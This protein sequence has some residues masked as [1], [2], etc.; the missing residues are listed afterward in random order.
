MNKEIYT[1]K[2]L[3]GIAHSRIENGSTPRFPITNHIITNPITQ[4]RINDALKEN[5]CEMKYITVANTKAQIPQTM[6]LIGCSG[7]I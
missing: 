1:S 3:N 4:Q 2:I 6:P 7:K 5:F